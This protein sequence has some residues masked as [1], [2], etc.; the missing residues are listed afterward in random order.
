MNLKIEVSSLQQSLRTCHT[1]FVCQFIN[2]W[3][4]DE[5]EYNN[6]DDTIS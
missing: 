5:N 2:L 4:S 1:I 3:M 6:K